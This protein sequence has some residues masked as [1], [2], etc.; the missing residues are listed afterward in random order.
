MLNTAIKDKRQ[1]FKPY[2]DA[3]VYEAV[4]ED[5]VKL[6]YGELWGIMGNNGE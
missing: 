1:A 2:T 5:Y 4:M 6:N 3:R